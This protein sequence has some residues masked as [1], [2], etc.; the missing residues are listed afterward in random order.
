MIPFYPSIQ[1]LIEVQENTSKQLNEIIMTIQG[2]KSE[3]D[4]EIIEKILKKMQDEIKIKVKDVITHLCGSTVEK[5]HQQNESSAGQ[6]IRIGRQN[7]EFGSIKEM[8]SI[9]KYMKRICK[10]PEMPQ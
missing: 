1:S 9:S 7:R 4:K 3:L 2:L 10:N 8:I 6:N 5:S